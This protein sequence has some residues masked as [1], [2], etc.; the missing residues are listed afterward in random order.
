MNAVEATT[1]EHGAQWNAI[2]VAIGSTRFLGSDLS[3]AA[4]LPIRAESP[5]GE[6]PG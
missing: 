6:S 2:A 1:K 4:R 3:S 5:S